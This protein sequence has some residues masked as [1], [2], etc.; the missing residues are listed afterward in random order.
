MT[1]SEAI[2]N[3][4]GSAYVILERTGTIFESE[5]NFKSCC[6]EGTTLFAGGGGICGEPVCEVEEG[7]S[8]DC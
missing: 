2:G 6:C 5:G 8:A 7:A 3:C 1:S 4:K